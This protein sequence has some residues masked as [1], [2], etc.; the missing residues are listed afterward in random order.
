MC[1]Q[2]MIS[3]KTVHNLINTLVYFT[4]LSLQTAY[5]SLITLKQLKYVIVK[6]LIMHP[7]V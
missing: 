4:F 3:V 5:K 6:R 1:L 2:N 7:S